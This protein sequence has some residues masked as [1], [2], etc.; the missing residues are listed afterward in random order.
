MGIAK[1]MYADDVSAMYPDAKKDVDGAFS[2]SDI[3]TGSTGFS[4]DTFED[5]PR[6]AISNWIDSKNRR[7]MVVEIYHKRGGIWNRCVF[8]AAGI[9]EAGPSR[10]SMRRSVPTTQSSPCP[11][12]WTA[13][14]TG[15]AS[16]ET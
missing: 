9:L 16:G 11:A 3:L 7:L 6:D 14:T 5:K 1:W 13:T 10:I 2:G 4:D 12:M 15:W 8:S